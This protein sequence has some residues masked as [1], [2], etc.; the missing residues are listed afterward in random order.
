MPKRNIFES[1]NRV[2]SQH[3]GEAGD[4]LG[5][6]GIPLMRHR[7][8]ALLPG[9]EILFRLSNFR[10]LKVA[11]LDRDF[12][13]RG[14]NQRKRRHVVRMTVALERLSRN[15]RRLQIELP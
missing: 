15:A 14:P 13:K 5:C 8:R 6:D 1:S 10:P 2:A 7:R 3:A 11:Y 9:G 4:L 12:F